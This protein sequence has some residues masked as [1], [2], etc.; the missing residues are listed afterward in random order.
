VLRALW[1]LP[2]GLLWTVLVL[3]SGTLAGI[4]T[5]GRWNHRLINVVAPV[6]GRV[7]LRIGGVRMRVVGRERLVTA[8]SRILVMNH[9]SMLDM[10][11]IAA[12]NPP[13]LM[14]LGK[15]EFVWMPFIGWAWWALGQAFVDRGDRR[16]AQESLS[17][18]ARRMGEQVRSVVVFPE[19]TRSRSGQLQPFKMGAFHLAVETRAPLVPMVIHGAARLQP[20]DTWRIQ[21]GEMVLELFP[22]RSTEHWNLDNLKA[23]VESLRGEYL[24]WLEA[25]PAR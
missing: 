12:L 22:E 10:L 5:L 7:L 20:P 9:Q 25:G 4:L 3:G 18:V 16:R 13:G 15:K 24:A 2:A 21:P 1:Y 17:T 6:W 23:E 8:R 11:A 14:A 19:G